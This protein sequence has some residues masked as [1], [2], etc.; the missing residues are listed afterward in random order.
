MVD[1]SQRQLVQAQSVEIFRSLIERHGK[2]V[3]AQCVRELRD[4]HLAEDVTQAV[5]MVLVRKYPSL[6]ENIVLPAWL[7]K[8][9]HFACANARRGELR[10]RRHEQ[11]A[12]M[13]RNAQSQNTMPAKAAG[14]L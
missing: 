5:F 9:T 11:E 2:A 12:A 13:T 14:D 10:R 8:V 3:Y 7:F 1:P 4:P 6:P